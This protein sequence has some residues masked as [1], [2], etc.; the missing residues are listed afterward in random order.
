MSMKVSTRAGD[1]LHGIGTR[2]R[3]LRRHDRLGVR[4]DS[5]SLQ[6]NDAIQLWRQ[7][8]SRKMHARVDTSRLVSSRLVWCLMREQQ[9]VCRGSFVVMF[10]VCT[11]TC[12]DFLL[13]C[14]AFLDFLANSSSLFDESSR[15]TSRRTRYSRRYSI[16]VKMLTETCQNY[17]RFLLAWRQRSRR[18]YCEGRHDARNQWS[19][20]NWRRL[21]LVGGGWKNLF[22]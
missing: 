10:L 4:H 8:G 14:Q 12:I 6:N 1:N 18:G 7:H 13:V 11:T 17:Q 3:R 5:Q 2:G 15:V 20:Y 9:W 16:H 22:R 19:F 21:T